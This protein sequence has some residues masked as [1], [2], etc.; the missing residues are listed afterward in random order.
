MKR[1]NIVT[2]REMKP[3]IGRKKKY[4]KRTTTKLMSG[5][6]IVKRFLGISSPF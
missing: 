4:L 5:D 1:I 6:I 3:R 2:K